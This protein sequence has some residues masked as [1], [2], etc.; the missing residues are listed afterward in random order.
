MVAEISLRY[1][2]FQ[3]VGKEEK[4]DGS[5]DGDGGGGDVGGRYL[6][7][8]KSWQGGESEEKKGEDL[9]RGFSSILSLEAMALPLKVNK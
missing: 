1:L 6:Y 5:G 4:V 8:P 2:T 3:R 9:M 7:L